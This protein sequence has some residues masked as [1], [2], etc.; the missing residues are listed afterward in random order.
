LVPIFGRVVPTRAS[1]VAQ[2]QIYMFALSRQKRFDGITLAGEINYKDHDISIPSEST[3]KEFRLRLFRVLGMLT[4]EVEPD[5]T[6]SFAECL[7]CPIAQSECLERVNEDP[8]EPL[9]GSFD[10]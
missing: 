2:V 5:K 7:F 8:N 3:D 6:P 9:V 1:D 10:F 4:S